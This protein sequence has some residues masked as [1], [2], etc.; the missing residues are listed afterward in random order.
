[1]SANRKPTCVIYCRLS[2]ADTL[3][4]GSHD[5]EA[6]KRQ[7]R[8]CR[9]YAKRQGWQV[10]E[11]VLVD[12]DLSASR[13]ARKSR[14]GW[15][16]L[17]GILDEGSVD[18]AVAS[19]LDRMTR[20]PKDLERLIDLAEKSPTRIVT[21]SGKIDLGDADGRA[22]AR[23]S[24]ALA[25]HYVESTSRR[26]KS[27]RKDRANSGRPVLTDAQ[28]G[29]DNATGKPI[30]EQANAIRWAAKHLL[31][32][33]SAEEVAREWNRR[34]LPR[35]RSTRPW[36]GNQVVTVLRSPRHAGWAKYQGATLS[37][38]LVDDNGK[39]APTILDPEQWATLMALLDDPKRGRGPRRRRELS[40]LLVCGKCGHTLRRGHI[41]PPLK[42]GTKRDGWSCPR[43][44]GGCGGL[45][46][47]ADPI[48]EAITEAVL[49]LTDGGIPE[50][51]PAADTSGVSA[52]LE[53]LRQMTEQLAEQYRLGALDLAAFQAA[54]SSIAS[55]RQSLVA[56]IP[57]SEQ[58][59]KLAVYRRPGALRK[60][61]PSLERETRNDVLRALIARVVVDPADPRVK[62]PTQR[63]NIEWAHTENPAA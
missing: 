28:F 58:S 51:P 22:M 29:W 14:P 1:M 60:A 13:Y 30:R 26:M 20:S 38:R 50:P 49:T 32:G 44:G 61:W 42:D 45:G 33:G 7:E 41:G 31:N 35:R 27:Q 17:V 3:P 57:E 16:Q 54:T 4:D 59:R 11:P 53:E 48:E 24:V 36:N 12:N 40:G 5:V 9:Q 19:H 47:M 46:I 15:K 23:V 63:L 52:R 25:S 37:V 39:P 21:L 56:V 43:S 10:I 55:E 8:E 18:Y 2:K 62:D 34:G 6:V